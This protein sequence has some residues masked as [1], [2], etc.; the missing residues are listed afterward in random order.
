MR[1]PLRIVAGLDDEL[2]DA[3]GFASV[4]AQAAQA[5]PVTLVAG[6]N[7]IGLTLQAQAV[8]AVVI[9]CSD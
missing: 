5:V 2:F 1:Q 7:H 6:V 4:F 8:A 3:N 9:A